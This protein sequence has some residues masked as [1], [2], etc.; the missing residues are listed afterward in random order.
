[1]LSNSNPDLDHKMLFLDQD[2]E[3]SFGSDGIWIQIHR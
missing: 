1:M 2:L 3:N